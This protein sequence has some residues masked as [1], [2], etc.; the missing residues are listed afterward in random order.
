MSLNANSTMY[1]IQAFSIKSFSKT[2]N[3]G[4]STIY[5]EISSGKL[6]IRKVESRTLIAHEDAV[7]WLNSLPT[8]P[9]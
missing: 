8:R 5:N 4:R 2:F 7:K 9:T 6:K 1:A 3:I